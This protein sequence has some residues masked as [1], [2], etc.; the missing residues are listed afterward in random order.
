MT[1]PGAR[2]G[3]EDGFGGALVD[4]GQPPRQWRQLES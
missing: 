1:G 4:E 2:Q 3:I